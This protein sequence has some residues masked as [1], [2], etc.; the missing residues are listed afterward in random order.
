MLAGRTASLTSP[1]CCAPLCSQCADG[2]GL[3]ELGDCGLV[4]HANFFAPR[5]DDPRHKWCVDSGDCVFFSCTPPANGVNATDVPAG[6]DSVLQHD[7]KLAEWVKGGADHCAE[8]DTIP[9]SCD[10]LIHN[11][12]RISVATIIVLFCCSVLIVQA[13]L[14]DMDDAMVRGQPLTMS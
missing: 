6:S 9:V 5:A 2:Y 7:A 14:D 1:V 11:H 3:T 12:R 13:I 10:H 4:N 8:T